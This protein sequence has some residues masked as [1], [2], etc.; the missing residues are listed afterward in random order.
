MGAKDLQKQAGAADHLAKGNCTEM[1]QLL[2][3]Q[4]AQLSAQDKQGRG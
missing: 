1:H 3:C 4:L 2:L